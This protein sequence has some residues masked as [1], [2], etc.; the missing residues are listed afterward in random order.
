VGDD[1]R[2]RATAVVLAG[3]ALAV[4][5]WWLALRVDGVR[6]RFE[7]RVDDRLVLDAFALPDLVV[8][9]GGSVLAAV[10]V[11][12]RAAWAP[13]AIAGVAGAATYATLHVVH[14]AVV[15]GR[16]WWAVACMVPL[17]AAD[18]ALAT[19]WARRPAG[20]AA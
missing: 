13:A 17:A 3:Q 16:S 1:A 20:G 8:L 5:A 2:R 9:V 7:L 14:H 4:A 11:T 18:L 19:W 10:A 6:E 15:A 12:R